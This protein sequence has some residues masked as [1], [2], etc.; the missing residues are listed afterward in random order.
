[1]IRTYRAL[2]RAMANQVTFDAPVADPPPDTFPAFLWWAV[3]GGQRVIWLGALIAVLAGATDIAAM[4]ILGDLVDATVQTP[5]G[6]WAAHWQLVVIALA[7]LLVVR[8]LLFG[9]LALTQSVMIGPNIGMQSLARLFRWTLGQSV[10][11]F[12]NDFAGR[13]AQ[14]LQQT[15]NSLTEMIIESVNALIFGLASVLATAILLSTINSWMLLVLAVWFLLYLSFLRVMLPIIRGR[16][17]A[18]AEK[19]A[20]V[21]GQV[22][23]TISNVKT[24]K[25]FAGDSHEDSKAISAMA[26][27]RETTL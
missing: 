22:V 16:S 6:F 7:L 24:V 11:F 18:R 12:D 13:I 1:M 10:S 14:K 23:D 25:L 26:D 17:S 8:P 21:T 20:M 19:R 3:K 27:L 2:I 5:S 4:A 15:A 9:G